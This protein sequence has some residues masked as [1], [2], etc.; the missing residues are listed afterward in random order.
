MATIGILSELGTTHLKSPNCW[1]GYRQT[2]LCLKE[3][4]CAGGD[5]LTGEDLETQEFKVCI[6]SLWL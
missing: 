2:V 6:M 3:Y 5:G 4:F 1:Q